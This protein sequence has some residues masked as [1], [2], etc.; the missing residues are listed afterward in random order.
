[1]RIEEQRS[2]SLDT[3]HSPAQIG[4][5][6]REIKRCCAAA[7]QSEWAK[8]LLGDCFHPG[9]LALTDHLGHVLGLKPN[10]RVLDV[11]AGNGASAMYLARTFGV[12]VVGVDYGSTAV[13]AATSSAKAAGIG[14]QV[15]FQQGDAEH[16]PFHAQ[17][18]DAVICE[19][20]FCTFPEKSAAASEFA[21][22]LKP[23]GKIGMTDL[24]RRG[25]TPEDLQGLLA[26]VAC[27]GAAQP[28]DAYETYLRETGLTIILSEEHGAALAQLVQDV[29]TRL[30]AAEILVKL[31]QVQ[32]PLGDFDRARALA[33][34]AA[35]AVRAG[36]FGYTLLMATKP[37]KMLTPGKKVPNNASRTG[38]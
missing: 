27:V 29:R 36:Q 38:K 17:Q 19:C 11:A 5:E 21:R 34:A 9:G 7:Y 16:L 8:W 2:S 32:L 35:D 3:T 31:K 24:T 18:F 15:R 6:P 30:L 22:V 10:M 13:E 1:V 28:L 23:G 37:E 4:I 33:R 26:W 25:E 20:A 12:A 14:E